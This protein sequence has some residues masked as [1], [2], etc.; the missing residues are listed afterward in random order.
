LAPGLCL[1]ECLCAARSASVFRARIMLRPA[2]AAVDG[3]D[4]RP[5]IE[6]ECVAKIINVR[7]S[8]DFSRGWAGTRRS[9]PRGGHL[10]CAP[11]WSEP[12]A[13]SRAYPSHFYGSGL[14]FCATDGDWYVCL[15]M[16]LYKSTLWALLGGLTPDCAVGDRATPWADMLLAA[17]AQ[18]VLHTLAR[19]RRAHLASHN[20]L[21]IDNV[22]YRRTTRRHVYV[23]LIDL[24]GAP[25]L[26]IPTHGRLYYVI[27]FG[28]S[29]TTVPDGAH[30]SVHIE[31]AAC[32]VAGGA[33]M[34]AWNPGTDPAQV[35][36]SLISAARRRL[37]CDVHA[38]IYSQTARSWWPL[39]DALAG[40]MAV[41]PR[42][43]TPHSGPPVV[44]PID[45]GNRVTRN[46]PKRSDQHVAG[47]PDGGCLPL[48]EHRDSDSAAHND[49][50]HKNNHD[51]DDKDD[52]SAWD[53]LFYAEISRSCHLARFDDFL[54][55]MIDRFSIS[56][57]SESRTD[58]PSARRLV[59]TY[60]VDDL[61]ARRGPVVTRP[62][63]CR[64]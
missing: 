28:W 10:V 17:L 33:A 12:I 11:A 15:V 60:V 45:Q 50:A 23:R 5:S 40:L 55:I 59:M 8:G 56:D 20:D 58:R 7:L 24:P 35:A 47:E 44:L 1:V 51:G 16:P 42:S 9:T 6:V 39:F 36:Y 62:L 2:L 19:A 31:S 13:L 25:L 18:V 54:T 63:L 4:A 38:S 46:L 27:D 14:F 34:R 64:R 26:A 3:A 52:D 49:G 41:G 48:G 53:D 61:I 22:A 32:E 37:G 43:A 21:K 29:S 30:R 57:S